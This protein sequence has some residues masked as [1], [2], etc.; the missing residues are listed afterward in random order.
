MSTKQASIRPPS[1]I[2]GKR[3]LIIE[4]EAL[5]AMD[6]QEELENAGSVV[7]GPVG[8]LEDAIAIA[9]REEID[10]AVVD[11]DLHGQQSYP[12]ADI[13]Q[14]KGTPFLWHTGLVER[15]TFARDYPGVPV[16][17]KPSRLDDVLSVIA[18]ITA[19]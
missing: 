11:V 13:L 5:F 16:V 6:L 4:D 19:P 8:T 1:S 14:R 3:V 12:A 2:A 10:A 7:V 15:E 18:S 9:E 17:Q